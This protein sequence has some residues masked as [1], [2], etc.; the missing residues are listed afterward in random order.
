M[1]ASTGGNNAEGREGRAEKSARPI[2]I[3]KKRQERGAF[4]RGIYELPLTAKVIDF[5]DDVE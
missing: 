1:R 5:F 2:K 4:F 3:P